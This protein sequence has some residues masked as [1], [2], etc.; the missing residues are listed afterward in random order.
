MPALKAFL[1]VAEND[2]ICTSKA[3]AGND[4]NSS[5]ATTDNPQHFM[6]FSLIIV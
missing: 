1:L 3:A 6:A 2:P 4:E 5:A